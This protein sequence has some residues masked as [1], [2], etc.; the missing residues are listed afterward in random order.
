M[1]EN[2]K[3]SR[4]DRVRDINTEKIGYITGKT[5]PFG[6]SLRW[7]AGFGEDE[8][9]YVRESFLELIAENEDMFSLF[10]QCRFNG[11][12]DLRRIIQQIRLNGNLTNLFYSMHNSSAKFMA[13]QFKPVM[14]FIESA[15]GHM[16][17]AD[18][19]GLG[20]TIEAIYIWKE[21]LTRENARRF[22]IICPAQLCQKW[23]DDLWRYFGIPSQI[24]GAEKLLERLNET[25]VNFASDSFVIISSIQSIRY[26][27][28]ENEVPI[29]HNNRFR[30]NDFFERFDAENNQELFDLVV[31]DEAHYLRNSATA[32]YNT[33]ERLRNISRYMILLSA[34]PIQTSS[35]N[36]YNLLRLL[37]PED[38]YNHFIFD[39]M[40]KENRYMVEFANAIR[41]NQP[42]TD[43]IERYKSIKEKIAD[44][45]NLD[46]RIQEYIKNAEN[47]TD[48]RMQLFHSIKDSN[49]YSQYFTRTRKRDV[50]EDR[51]T[52][53]AE[54]LTYTLSAEEYQKYTEVTKYLRELSVGSSLSKIFTLIARQRQMTSCLP[55]ALKHWKD[56]DVMSEMIY[57]DMGFDEEDGISPS[58]FNDS[59]NLDFPNNII[60][61]FTANDS[62]YNTLLSALRENIRVNSK[63]KVIIFSYYRYTINYLFDRL[64]HDGY[65]CEKIMGGMGDEKNDIIAHFRDSHDCNILIS[66]EVG[67]EGIDLQFASI[68]INYDLPWNPMRLEQRIGRIDR[69]GQE[70]DKIRILN[71]IC[72]NTIEDRVLER[73]YE[74]IEIF[75]YSIGD[76]EEILGG[77]IN[78]LSIELFKPNLTEQERL[79]RSFQ[80]IEAIALKKLDMEKLEE[81]AGL[82]A[83]FS[84]IILNNINLAN[85]NKRYIMAEELIQYTQDFFARNYAGSK[86]EKNDAQS[87]FIT[88]STEAQMDF[89]DYIRANHYHVSSL[90]YRSEAI[91]CI[92]N[93]NRDSYKKYRIYELIDIN[94]PFIKWMKDVSKGRTSSTYSCSAVKLKNANSAGLSN[95]L[96]AY[97]VQNWISEGYKNSKELKYFVIN[98][99]TKELID[100]NMA[101]NLIV[102]I[103]GDGTDYSEIRYGLNDYDGLVYSLNKCKEYA[104]NKFNSF[105]SAFISE[106]QLI[107]DRNKEYLAR[108]FDRKI[109]SIKEQI[110]KVRNSGQSENIIKMH[111]GRLR[112]ADETFHIQ[113][114]KLEAKKTGQCTFA[115]A[116]VGLIRIED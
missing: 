111:E 2:A 71:F 69:I 33:G 4:G 32:S 115:D 76:V 41:S 65:N 1:M 60:D 54:T 10:E 79:E 16:L 61:R 46:A 55:A 27:E 97:Y 92:F 53:E 20:K 44:N 26:R 23:K 94:H 99:E 29:S 40:L 13:H 93:N 107:C 110:Q 8:P 86:I 21:L 67:S 87:C 108:T 15:T 35:E 47:S 31:I 38:F 3:F 84:D 19:V 68:E 24:L 28:Q 30:L 50:L 96:Y 101:E 91:L 100:E 78:Q 43:I 37:A 85:T 89:C 25:M 57:E 11:V 114:K 9:L 66:S 42:K 102:N 82:S 73:L 88:L 34:T 103:L 22:L 90:G 5:M 63:E 72:Q 83:E 58:Q 51:I 98:T 59:Y 49:F 113:M 112:K 17:I 109:I 6:D 104:N 95:G 70:K 56:N 105:E 75:K 64:T 74:R 80:K 39:D 36:L 52:R 7:Q 81:Q 12:L 77:E 106:N 45:E 18:E 48:E 116:A 14:K 62:K